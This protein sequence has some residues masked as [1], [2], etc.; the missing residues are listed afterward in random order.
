L[1]EVS[2]EPATMLFTSGFR[3]TFFGTG[4]LLR[5]LRPLDIFDV[6]VR[7]LVKIPLS[8]PVGSTAIDESSVREIVEQLLKLVRALIGA[9]FIFGK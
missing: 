9:H 2:A 7:W 6:S 8:T 4:D 3:H 1:P 5:S